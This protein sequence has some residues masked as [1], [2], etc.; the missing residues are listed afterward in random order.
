MHEIGKT[1]DNPDEKELAFLIHAK[2]EGSRPEWCISSMI[3]SRDTPFWSGTL[4]IKDSV[5][6]FKTY[7]KRVIK[8]EVNLQGKHSV[9]VIIAY[10][11]ASSAEIEK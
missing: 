10:A 11:P 4:E 5:T 1:E 3:N 7:S 8:M 6:D 2:I 9:T